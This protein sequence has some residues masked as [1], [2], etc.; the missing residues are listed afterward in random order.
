MNDTII[1]VLV[2]ILAIWLIDTGYEANKKAPEIT[3]KLLSKS[4]DFDALFAAGR[5][6]IG[7]ILLILLAAKLFSS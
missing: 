2:L 1:D 6:V 7:V 3:W 5:I 4:A